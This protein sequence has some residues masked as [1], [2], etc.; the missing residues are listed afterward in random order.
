MRLFNRSLR[1]LPLLLAAAL[2]LPL[3]SLSGCS[4]L[5]SVLTPAAQPF[6]QVA[7]D[8]A[9]ATAVGSNAATQKANAVKIKT[10]AT[11]VLTLD[12]G[13][14]VALSA[15]EAAV[16]AKI[17]T[18]N[19]PPADLAAANLLTA[20]LAAVIQ[21]KLSTSAAGA[22]TAT[23]QVAVADIANDVISACS[24]YGA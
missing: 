10:I 16:N 17:A 5:A 7:V 8:A 19:L 3:L 15:V 6:L 20:T 21:T 4:T 9:V 22:V 14:M 1:L 11:E 24:A 13:T 18:L 23:T 2:T 12:T